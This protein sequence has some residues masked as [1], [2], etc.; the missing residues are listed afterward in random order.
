MVEIIDYN[1]G[2]VKSVYNALQFLDANPVIIR[3]PSEMRE[4]KVIIPGV[5]AFGN[6]INNLNPFIP[7]IRELS[8]SEI[9]ILGIC[10]GFQMFF[11]SSEESPNINGLGIMKGKVEKINTTLRLPHIGWNYLL[12]TKKQCPIF[13]AI[14][15]GYVYFVHSF[16]PVPKENIISATTE[17]ENHI[18][19][20]VW[21]KNI[22][23][24]QFH[25]EKSGILG[26]DILRNFVEL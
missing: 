2:N 5:G 14:N 23:G 17:Y 4:E 12:I 10:L 18:C 15:N 25:P 1:M 19:A 3:R 20:S 24:T 11:E 9:P 8:S 26:L 13:Y 22:F 21:K 6:G 7:K 16:Q